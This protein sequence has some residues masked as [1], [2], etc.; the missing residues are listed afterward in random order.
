MTSFTDHQILFSNFNRFI[1]FTTIVNVKLTTTSKYG[2]KSPLPGKIMYEELTLQLH[3]STHEDVY[4]TLNDEI[5]WYSVLCSRRS[6]IYEH[7][8]L[9]ETAK[10]VHSSS[11]ILKCTVRYTD[12]A[13]SYL[14]KHLHHRITSKITSS[15]NIEKDIHT[16][17]YISL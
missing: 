6:A 12:C 7:V 8:M 14:P 17:L 5:V 1:T 16:W 2:E 4:T 3:I 9:L 11:T 15:V 10:Y 13:F